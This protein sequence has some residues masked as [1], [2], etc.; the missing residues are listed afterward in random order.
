MIL[1]S[2]LDNF[3]IFHENQGGFQLIIRRNNHERAQVFM[4]SNRTYFPDNNIN[5]SRN[6]V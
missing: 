1:V 5:I 2:C 3:P 6:H 4:K